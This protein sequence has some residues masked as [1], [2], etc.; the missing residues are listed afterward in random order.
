MIK[1][2][3]LKLLLLV[4]CFIGTF[5]SADFEKTLKSLKYRSKKNCFLCKE[6]LKFYEKAEKI[7]KTKAKKATSVMSKQIFKTDKNQKP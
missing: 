4:S 5:Y 1:F 7:D 3:I 6:I 2:S